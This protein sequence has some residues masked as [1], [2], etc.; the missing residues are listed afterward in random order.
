MKIVEINMVANGSTGTIMLNLAGLAREQGNE[1]RTFSARLFSKPRKSLPPAPNGHSYFGSHGENRIHTALGQLTGLNGLFSAIGTAQL[2]RECKKIRPDVIHLHNL[3]AFCIDL[4]MLFRYIKKHKIPV[5]WTLHDCWTLTG[6]CPHFVM[7]GCDKWRTE[8]HHCPQLSVYPKSRVDNVR[9]AHRLKK[10][11]FLGVENMTLVTPS[12]WLAHLAEQSF[13]GQYPVK[14]IHN[15][16]NLSVFRPTESDFREK[17]GLADKKILL[18]VIQGWDKRKGIDVFQELATRLDDTYKLILVGADEATKQRLPENILCIRRTENQAQLAQIY[19]MADL[20]LN[21]TREDTFPTT[22]IESLACGTP[23]LTFR[24][25]GS[26]ECID[27]TCGS[28]IDVDD[29]DAMEKEIKRICVESPYSKD[30][31]L[32]R[33]RS[34]DMNYR[35]AEYLELYR[36]VTTR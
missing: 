29:I 24:T 20:F 2:I 27:D 10:K 31:C 17:Y 26:P 22:N 15:G 25:G 5:V 13:M 14:V 16:I 30:A 35:F 28:V 8:C 6:H 1:A 32:A 34:F 12:R 18:G 19:T 36:E 33:A 23:V 11:W 7:A 9:M 21:P 3:H 4:P